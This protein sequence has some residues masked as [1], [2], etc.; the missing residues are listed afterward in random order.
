MSK[1]FLEFLVK[2]WKR[3]EDEEHVSDL[4]NNGRYNEVDAIIAGIDYSEFY[5]YMEAGEKVAVSKIPAEYMLVS[6]VYFS[7]NEE[8]T[9]DDILDDYEE[10]ANNLYEY[11]ERGE[12]IGEALLS[13]EIINGF[14]SIEE[15]VQAGE[16]YLNEEDSDEDGDDEETDEDEDPDDEDSDAE[17]ENGDS[18]E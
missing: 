18:E 3:L 4:F 10:Y 11:G 1:E 12:R 5:E 14:G 6:V 15:L 7:G 13:G 9:D 8:Y 17:D 2:E 16:E